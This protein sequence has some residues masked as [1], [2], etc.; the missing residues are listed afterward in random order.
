MIG[1]SRAWGALAIVTVAGWLVPA[2]S[3]TPLPAYPM[4]PDCLG[5]ATTGTLAEFAVH[6][7]L[8]VVGTVSRVSPSS[9]PMVTTCSPPQIVTSCGGSVIRPALV[10]E[11]SDLRVLHGTFT[12]SSLVVHIG[13][14]AMS[15]WNPT[16][17]GVAGDGSINW[18]PASAPGRIEAGQRIAAVL[19]HDAAEGGYAVYAEPLAEV[20][21]D[22]KLVLQPGSQCFADVAGFDGRTVEEVAA[23][24]SSTDWSDP[25]LRDLG[26]SLHD[27]WTGLKPAYRAAYFDAACVTTCP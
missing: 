18:A 13:Q 16:P 19:S 15:K 23:A 26:R 12:G 4:F 7:D 24:L 17:S 9:T 6:G 21:A 3:P 25:K 11:L 20:G 27:E 1:G 5:F 14:G 8:F 10:A 2:C 22:G